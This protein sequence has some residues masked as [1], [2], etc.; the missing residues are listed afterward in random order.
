MNR[1]FFILCVVLL[2]ACQEPHTAAH[3][4]R[5]GLASSP[6]TMDPRYAT[7]A[8]SHRVQELVHCSLVTLGED[9]LPKPALAES[10]QHPDPYSWTFSLNSDYNFHDGHPVT[11]LDVAATIRAVMDKSLSSPLRASFNAIDQIQVSER[12]LTITLHKPDA[13]LLTKLNLGILPVRLA[14]SPHNARKTMG[15]GPYKLDNW[16]NSGLYLSRV[17]PREGSNIEH[18]QIATIKDPVTRV[19]KL[20]RNEIDFTQNDLPPHLLPWLQKQD[21]I[22]LKHQPSTTFSY[23]GMNMQDAIL[24]NVKVRHALAQ[25]I[26]RST[27]KRA[28]FADLPTL[29]ETVLTPK[30]W[31]ATSLAATVYNPQVAEKLLDEAGYPKNSSGTR[32]NLTY[33]TS[34][35]PTRLRLVTAI[36]AAWE[37]IGV[38]VSI[39]SLEWGGFYARIKSG[40]FQLFSLSW[41]GITDPDIYRWILHSEMQPPKGANRGRYSNPEVDAWL[42]QASLSENQDERQQLYALVQQQMAADQVYIPLWYDAVVAVSGQRL[43]GFQ[44]VNSGSLLPLLDARLSD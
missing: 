32:F 37:K 23:I 24:K 44:P 21:N 27:L 31:A 40:D 14:Q 29:G 36:A 43:Q 25:A 16:D 26:D 18:I 9:F 42:D 13:S 38:H 12:K 2:S 20:V 19:L 5:I 39:E 10:W 11:A 7:D 35:N 17:I 1:L 6:I 33:R 15:C 28:L 22:T 3:T 34:T 4:L 41:V 30:H 8:A